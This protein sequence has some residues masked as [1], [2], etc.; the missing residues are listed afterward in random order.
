M[1]LLCIILALW[2]YYKGS[3]DNQLGLMVTGL[4]LAVGIVCYWIFATWLGLAGY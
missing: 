3:R 4:I 2:L 1:E